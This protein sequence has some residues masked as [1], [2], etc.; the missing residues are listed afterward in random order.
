MSWQGVEGH[1]RVADQFRRRLERGRLASTYLFVGPAGVGKRT[2]A[3]RL[4]AALLCPTPRPDPLEACGRCASCVQVAAGTHPDLITVSKPADRAF[5]PLKLLIGEDDKRMQEG[6]CHEIA[7][8]P[9]MGGRRIAILDD[10][11]HLNTEGANALLKTLE[12]PPPNTVLI[13]IG[14]SI[15]RQL[16]TIRSRAQIVRF[17]PLE[18]ETVAGLLQSKGLVNDAAEAARLAR[19]SEGSLEQAQQRSE[20]ELWQFR[21]DLLA[22]LSKPLVDTIRLAKMVSAFVDAAGKEAP[23]RRDRLR[24]VLE[25]SIDFYRQSVRAMAGAPSD[26]DDELVAAVNVWLG[27]QTI[28]LDAATICCE[29]CLAALV[30]VDRNANQSTMIE[31]WVDSLAR[32]YLASR[33]ATAAR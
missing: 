31:A 10:A 29:D 11:D 23:A 6:L 2:F 16:P 25:F 28:T 30:Q 32:R 9:Y 27:H 15:D 24:L 1:D 26:A 8:K 14:T 4:A 22:Q 5:I 12:E 17:A 18:E 7:L 19:Y 21:S 20:P 3:L 33:A 13:L